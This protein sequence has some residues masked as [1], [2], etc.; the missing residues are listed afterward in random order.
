M[1]CHFHRIWT[2]L[3][4]LDIQGHRNWGSVWLQKH[5]IQTPQEVFAWMSRECM[6][7]GVFFRRIQS[8]G[9]SAK[10]WAK[11]TGP[12]VRCW[13]GKGG[14]KTAATPTV[15]HFFTFFQGIFIEIQ[16]YLPVNATMF[17]Q[18]RQ[19]RNPSKDPGKPTPLGKGVAWWG[20]NLPWPTHSC[21]TP[22]SWTPKTG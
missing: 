8:F 18:F 3:I 13:W 17:H 1:E 14:V 15:I 12:W 2:L 5:T 11:Q 20:A 16:S 21:T 4:T 9:G 6:F 10:F 7:R 19:P 22:P